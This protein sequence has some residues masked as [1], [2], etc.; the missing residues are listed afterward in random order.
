MLVGNKFWMKTEPTPYV[1]NHKTVLFYI[2][3]V[4]ERTKKPAETIIVIQ[5]FLEKWN[6]WRLWCILNFVNA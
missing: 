2:C 3:I 1:S 5:Q 6:I 4:W